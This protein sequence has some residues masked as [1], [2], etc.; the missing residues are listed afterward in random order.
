MTDDPLRDCPT[1]G[2][3]VRRVI[4]QVGVLKR[5]EIPV[6]DFGKALGIE[7][8]VVIQHDAQTFG[9]ASSNGQM[10][11]EVGAKSK[12]AEALMSLAQLIAGHEPPSKKSGSLLAPL[13]NKLPSL[14][15]K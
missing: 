5:P 4:N 12:A 1:C 11:A 7:P 6:A 2:G 13:M 3:E 8:T 15:K 10:I 14:R 9:T